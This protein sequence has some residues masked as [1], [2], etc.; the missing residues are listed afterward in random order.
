MTSQT[1]GAVYILI[2]QMVQNRPT[3]TLER[4]IPLTTIRAIGMSTLRDDWLTINT[5]ASEQGDPIISC[6]FKTE[7]VT[8]L[9]Q[10]TNNGTNLLIGPTVQYAKKKDKQAAIKFTRDEQVQRGDVYK[11]SEVRVCSGEPANSVSR[12]PAARKVRPST[13]TR[14]AR[15]PRAGAASVRSALEQL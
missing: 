7:F 8:H 4:K 6:V 13:S 14:P 2:S 3:T 15:A 9:Q 12:P 5:T 1:N 11:S 10:L